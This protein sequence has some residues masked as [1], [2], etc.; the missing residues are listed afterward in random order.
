M[1]DFL[2]PSLGVLG[3]ATVVWLQTVSQAFAAIAGL[4]TVCGLTVG[5][6]IQ[7]KRLKQADVDLMRAKA[8]EAEVEV[9]LCTACQHGNRPLHCPFPPE[10]RPNSCPLKHNKP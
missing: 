2:Q 8:E 7:L 1:K 6:I 9:D 3:T 10:R 5:F 4:L